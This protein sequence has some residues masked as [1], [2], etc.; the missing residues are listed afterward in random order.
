[1]LI[2]SLSIQTIGSIATSNHLRVFR[3]AL[4]LFMGSYAPWR[5]ANQL[6]HHFKFYYQNYNNPSD[7]GEGDRRGALPTKESS[8]IDTKNN[9]VF[10]SLNLKLD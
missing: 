4:L 10:P 2:N 7:K 3:E 8:V 1:M 5:K 9:Q 6:T